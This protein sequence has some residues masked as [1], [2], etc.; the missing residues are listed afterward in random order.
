MSIQEQFWTKTTPRKL[1]LSEKEQKL[2][3]H[4]QDIEGFLHITHQIIN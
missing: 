4:L 2:F 1:K 3:V